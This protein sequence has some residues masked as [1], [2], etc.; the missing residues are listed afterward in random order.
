MRKKEG[1]GSVPLTNGSGSGRPTNVRIRIRIPN[2]GR[3]K[4][5]EDQN[6]MHMITA[7]FHRYTEVK[8]TENI[9]L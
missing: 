9:T 3:N 5:F 8:K 7:H 2:N 1:S 6:R 4:D